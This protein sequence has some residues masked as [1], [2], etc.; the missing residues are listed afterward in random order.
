M[1]FLDGNAVPFEPE[2]ARRVFLEFGITEFGDP[3]YVSLPGG[4][5]LD[6][7]TAGIE[8]DAMMSDFSIEFRGLSA[9]LFEFIFRLCDEAHLVA[10]VVDTPALPLVAHES[11]IANIPEEIK[12]EHAPLLC[13]TKEAVANV[14]SPGFNQWRKWADDRPTNIG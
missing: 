10:I 14:I 6:C 12:A 13:L 2:Q 3:A 1:H 5:S 11:D 9:S 8:S 4:P 7:Y